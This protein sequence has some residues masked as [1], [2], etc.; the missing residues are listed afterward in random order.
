MK[1][2][3]SNLG[4]DWDCLRP[5]AIDLFQFLNEARIILAALVIDHFDLDQLDTKCLSFDEKSHQTDIAE[6]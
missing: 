1:H 6:V 5:S 4:M 2:S 3:L